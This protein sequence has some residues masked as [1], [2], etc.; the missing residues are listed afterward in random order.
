LDPCPLDEG[1]KPKKLQIEA[2]PTWHHLQKKINWFKA[3]TKKELKKE[4]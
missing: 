2:K 3:K 4:S 1:P